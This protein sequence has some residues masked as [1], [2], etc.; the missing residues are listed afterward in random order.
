MSKN[1]AHIIQK[2]QVEIFTSSMETGKL[3]ERDMTAFIRN[4]I[5]PL[6]EQYLDG[7]ESQLNNESLQIPLLSLDIGFAKSDFPAIADLDMQI[8]SQMDNLQEKVSNFSTH[9]GSFPLFKNENGTGTFGG[10]LEGEGF[11][12]KKEAGN[13]QLLENEKKDFQAWMYFLETGKLPWWYPVSRAK[14][15]FQL[16]ALISG[17]EDGL[18]RNAVWQKLSNPV[19]FQRL[20]SQ[21]SGKVLEEFLW[22][23]LGDKIPMRQL[24][25]ENILEKIGRNA[26]EEFYQILVLISHYQKDRSLPELR[27]SQPLIAKGINKRPRSKIHVLVQNTLRKRELAIWEKFFQELE[28]ESLREKSSNNGNGSEAQ[29]VIIDPLDRNQKR[30]EESYYID[31]AGLILIHPFLKA[32][33]SDCGFLDQKGKLIQPELAVHALYY[34]ASRGVAPFDF[35]LIFEKYLCGLDFHQLIPRD[36]QLNKSIRQKTDKLLG[37]L[38]EHWGK[39]KNTGMETVRNE[40]LTRNGK[41]VL[42]THQDRLI[43]ERKAQDILLDGLPWNL[44]I[45]QLPWRKKLLMVEW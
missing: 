19:F 27:S 1:K 2:V 11:K 44:S 26:Q 33:F 4:S 5:L 39:L 8:S 30:E 42:E 10:P 25:Y 14:I 34:L 23:I 13:A 7:M 22:F 17:L 3:M 36:I 21:Y 41:L 32:F 29:E 45:I 20:L 37:S 6:I 40:F 16:K 31:H 38:L 18:K 12:D 24:D 43:V 9:K 35:E 15:N 28:N